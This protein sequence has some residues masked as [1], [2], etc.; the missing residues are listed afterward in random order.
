MFQR[1]VAGQILVGDLFVVDGVAADEVLV[2]AQEG[3]GVNVAVVPDEDGPAS[4]L[5]DA[6]ELDAGIVGT[7]PMEGLAGDNKVNA[8][9]RQARGFGAAIYHSEGGI[10]GEIVFAGEA[11]FAIGFDSDDAVAVVEEYLRQHAGAAA[12]V[13]DEVLG[14]ETAGL[15]Q[16]LDDLGRVMRAILHVVFSAVGKAR[17]GMAS[18]IGHSAILT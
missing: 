13:G 10:S 7:K 18:A 12:D 11:H 4:R 6:R 3:R 1:G 8:R 15:L 5:E 14:T 17:C 2:G 16:R 9:V